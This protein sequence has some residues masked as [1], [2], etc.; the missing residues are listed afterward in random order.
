MPPIRVGHETCSLLAGPIDFVSR[1]VRREDRR[2]ARVE[3][4][5]VEVRPSGPGQ[6]G[7]QHVPGRHVHAVDH[8]VDRATEP[9][10]DDRP[11]E[12]DPRDVRFRAASPHG[13]Q[14]SQ[15]RAPATITTNARSPRVASRRMR[16]GSRIPRETKRGPGQCPD[17]L[18]TGGTP[19]RAPHQ[20]LRSYCQRAWTGGV[21]RASSR[22]PRIDTHIALGA[23]PA[24]VGVALGVRDTR[25]E[26]DGGRPDAVGVLRLEEDAD[27]LASVGNTGGEPPGDE[28]ADLGDQGRRAPLA[29]ARS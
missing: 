19:R 28:L 13:R 27:G 23:L 26:P 8:V 6:A 5:E 3:E 24:E 22:P 14:A 12:R 9:P 20:A 10:A 17:P 15:S 7:H 21:E 11:G 29:A 16:M 4:V 18:F 25:G 2:R 1:P